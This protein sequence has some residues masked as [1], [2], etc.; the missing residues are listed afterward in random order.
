MRAI[1]VI[2]SIISLLGQLDLCHA[3]PKST[4]MR[5]LDMYAKWEQLDYYAG[6]IYRDSVDG[7][8]GKVQQ[9]VMKMEKL[10]TETT[11][12]NVTSV[13]GVRALRNTIVQVKHVLSSVGLR[14]G[15]M[16]NATAKL[17]LATD[18]IIHP[19]QAMWLQYEQMLRDDIAHMLATDTQEDWIP[20]AQHWLQHV[21]RILPAAAIQCNPQIIEIM[22]SLRKLVAESILG[23][24]TPKDANAVLNKYNEMVMMQLF[25]S[26]KAR[27][28]LVPFVHQPMPLQW[29]FMLAFIVCIML[30][31]VAYQRYHYEQYAIRPGSFRKKKK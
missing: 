5:N 21:D 3:I 11:F 30:A 28:A 17:H 20:L 29:A 27:A 19:K 18:A 10:L 22:E 4:E 25:G 12:N 14:Q 8:L 2:I 24:H 16:V 23:R 26:S 31:Y 6:E 15:T 7:K 9:T 1:M 13:E